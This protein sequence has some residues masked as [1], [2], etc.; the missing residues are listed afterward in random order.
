[1]SSS[2][3]SLNDGSR[4]IVDRDRPPDRAPAALRLLLIGVAVSIVLLV[5]LPILMFVNQA[6]LVATIERETAGT[7]SQEWMDRVVVFVMIYSI[8]LHLLDVILLVWLTP[9]VLRGRQWA[10]ITLTA[11]LAA[12][13]AGSLYSASKGGMYLAVV[14]PTDLLHVIMVVLLWAPPSVRRFFARQRASNRFKR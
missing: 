11:Y 14:I 8:V 12:A 9:K 3:Q 4:Q 2:E 7:L 10:R 6:E 13:T 5:G 1:M